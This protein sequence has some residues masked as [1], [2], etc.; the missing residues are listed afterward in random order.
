MEDS[1]LEQRLVGFLERAKDLLAGPELTYWDVAFP[2]DLGSAFGSEYGKELWSSV[3]AVLLID[4]L[5]KDKLLNAWFGGFP[6][7]DF[8]LRFRFASITDQWFRSGESIDTWVAGNLQK[9]KESLWDENPVAYGLLLCQ[10]V[11][12]QNEIRLPFGLVAV[13]ANREL[14]ERLPEHFPIARFE[15]LRMPNQPTVYLLASSRASRTEFSG[16]A[17]MIAFGAAMISVQRLREQIWLASGVLPTGGDQFYWHASPFPPGLPDRIHSG[18]NVRLKTAPVLAPAV[19]VDPR[20]LHEIVVRDWALR[21]SEDNL[22]EDETWLSLWMARTFIHAALNATES[23]MCF[24]MSYATLDGLFRLD[25]ERESRLGPRIAMLIGGST[26]ERKTIRRFF[27]QAHDL[28]G[29]AAHGTRPHGTLLCEALDRKFPS[30]LTQETWESL[31]EELYRELEL[32]SLTILRRSLVAYYALATRV[33]GL[34][35]E[36]KAPVVE[37]FLTRTQILS[38]LE[39]GAA[40]NAFATE[41]LSLAIPEFAR[42][43]FPSPLKPPPLT[44]PTP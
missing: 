22:V 29:R 9:I 44:P 19:E 38:L 37:R 23:L 20:I 24:L 43:D 4:D 41:L 11:T 14:L 33:V 10:G 21:Q 15:I 30:D 7:P 36:T 13:G 25:G 1:E 17:A 35:S 40:N 5:M 12:I 26:E 27:Q 6:Q 8:E 42:V 34:G 2:R 18:L 32:K 28:R 16:G 31:R 3:D 39:A